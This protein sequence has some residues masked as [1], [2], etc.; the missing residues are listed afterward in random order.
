MLFKVQAPGYELSWTV[1]GIAAAIIFGLALLAGRY[2][3]AARKLPARLGGQAMRGTPAEILDWS[4]EAGHVRASGER[5]RASGSGAFA[6]GEM[7]E[8]TSVD[9]LTLAVR[10]R[11]GET[12]SPGEAR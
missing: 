3:W 5:W 2:L 12:A 7:V 11:P 4:N 9:G 1:L 10:R 6:L 8:V